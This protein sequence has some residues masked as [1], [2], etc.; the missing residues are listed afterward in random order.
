MSH[1]LLSGSDF[2]GMF[3][4]P[5][6]CLSCASLQLFDGSPP[7]R[8]KISHVLHV[9]WRQ[10]IAFVRDHFRVLLD[11]LRSQPYDVLDFSTQF[12]LDESSSPPVLLQLPQIPRRALLTALSIRPFASSFASSFL[13]V[14][15]D[16]FNRFFS[17]SSS[18]SSGLVPDSIV[19]VLSRISIFSP[20]ALVEVP[21]RPLTLLS[22][23]ASRPPV[24]ASTACH[25]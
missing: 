23:R 18:D 2:L 10:N 9:F 17:H 12:W 8:A 13:T 24:R 6:P 25:H 5:F 15:L 1:G 7:F 21:S 4:N 22:A 3:R 19:I 16:S 14:L 20:G 11:D